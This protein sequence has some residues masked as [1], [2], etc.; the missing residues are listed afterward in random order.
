MKIT[1]ISWFKKALGAIYPHIYSRR[2]APANMNENGETALLENLI[3][4]RD[5]HGKAFVCFDVGAN[6]GGY[7]KAVLEAGY[8]H[9]VP[10][11]IHAF[12][13]VAQSWSELS[14]IKASAHDRFI[15]N[16]FALSDQ[17]GQATMYYDKAGSS[18]ASIYKRDI[19]D[20]N[21]QETISAMTGRDYMSKSQTGMIDLLKIDVE[22]HELKVLEGFGEYLGPQ[23]IHTI[24]FEYG[25]SYKDSHTT[26]RDVYALL[27]GKGYVIGKLSRDAV[28]IRG[29]VAAMED[30]AY[31]N[32]VAL[33][34]AMAK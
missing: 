4:S 15:P 18:L 9:S 28:E 3:A 14:R 21:S 33:D 25:G 32:Y 2:A 26:L 6:I 34:P 24:Q 8:R 16:N 7:A 1:R 13:P 10:C 27:S 17:E 11:E 5:A 30:F 23:K 31:A 12:E 19:A 22:G 29:Y 20:F